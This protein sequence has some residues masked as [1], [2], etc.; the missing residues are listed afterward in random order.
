MLVM[1]FSAFA[2]QYK[3]IVPWPAGSTPDVQTR[4]ILNIVSQNTNDVFVMINKPGADT[5]I[6]YKHFLEE[7][8]RDKNILFFSHTPYYTML[9]NDDVNF[10]IDKNTRPIATIQKFGYHL[11]AR[12]DSPINHIREVKGKL[13]IMGSVKLCMKSLEAVKKDK[14]LQF[15]VSSDND[16]MLGLIRGDVDLA[17]A[18]GNSVPYLAIKDKT[19]VIE[20]FENEV[21]VGSTSAFIA[22]KDMSDATANRLNA[23]INQAYKDES[24]KS[25]F[26]EIS[27]MPP[28]SGPP[29]LYLK[30]VKELKKFL[31]THKVSLK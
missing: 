24:L 1:S 25:W 20:G 11:I 18:G 28:L 26:M 16:A 4:K 12:K 19:K 29:E 14:D 17:C 2:E 31:D 21:N 22:H 3:V 23:A 15:V 6:G 7:T 27:T 13:N 8:E 9:M 5:L 30:H 10:S